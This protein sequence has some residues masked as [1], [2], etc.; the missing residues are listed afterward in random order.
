MSKGEQKI[1]Q[2]LQKNN[3][4]FRKEQTF[5]DLFSR[6]KRPL[7][8]DFALYDQND[9]IYALIEFDGE[10]HYTFNKHFSKNNNN[11]KYRQELDLIKNQYALANNL[12]LFR[13]PYY[14]FDKIKTYSDLFQEEY[15]V[16]SKW[17]CYEI[18]YE[19]KL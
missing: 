15:K 16:K 14:D 9:K 8:Y 6:R 2:I 4:N 5:P 3:I 13:I 1:V 19:N 7:R 18:K 12:S 10:Q 17:H 11:F